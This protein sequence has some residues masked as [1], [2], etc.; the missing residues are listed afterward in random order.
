MWNIIVLDMALQLTGGGNVLNP[1]ANVT[2]PSATSTPTATA[3]PNPSGTFSCI[4]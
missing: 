3:P 2:A 4:F 1:G